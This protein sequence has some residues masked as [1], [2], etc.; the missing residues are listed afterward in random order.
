MAVNCGV[1]LLPFDPSGYTGLAESREPARSP[2][3]SSK[4]GPL[5]AKLSWPKCL[6]ELLA[7]L[8]TLTGSDFRQKHCFGA[9][10]FVFLNRVQRVLERGAEHPG[11]GL[12]SSS[13]S[14]FV[15]HLG[16]CNPCVGT[17]E[18]GSRGAATYLCIPRELRVGVPYSELAT[19][20]PRW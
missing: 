9:S 14:G 11:V 17:R 18:G 16:S 12:G 4:E 10:G 1:C 6:H 19:L 15:H 8:A 13:Q 20:R 2:N 5:V 7:L 3:A